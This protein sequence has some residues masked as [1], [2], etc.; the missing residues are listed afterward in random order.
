MS[1]VLQTVA[2]ILRG[3]PTHRGGSSALGCS[4]NS[5]PNRCCHKID[6]LAMARNHYSFA[7]FE[8][9]NDDLQD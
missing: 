5:H 3:S 7:S 2:G 4:C 6:S 1:F 8:S 9:M